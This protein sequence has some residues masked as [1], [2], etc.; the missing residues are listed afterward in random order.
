VNLD[1]IELIGAERAGPVALHAGVLDPR[2][3]SVATRSNSMT[4]WINS[5]IAPT[6]E[7]I[8]L[9]GCGHQGAQLNDQ[10]FTWTPTY[11][12]AGSYEVTLAAG[13]GEFNTMEVS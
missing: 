12:Q 9:T 13:D 1:E 8:P 7:V 3:K 4:S 10:T 2:F 6:R 11:D 5:L